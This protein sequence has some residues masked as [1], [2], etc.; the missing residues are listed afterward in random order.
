MVRTRFFILLGLPRQGYLR[1]L[2]WQ[3]SQWVLFEQMNGGSISVPTALVS[4]VTRLD[5][6]S[7]ENML[8]FACNKATEYKPVKLGT[9]RTVFLPSVSQ[10]PLVPTSIT[11][12]IIEFE[13]S[14]VVVL[15]W[16]SNPG[17]QNGRRSRIHG[18]MDE[19]KRK[20]GRDLPI[21]LKKVSVLWFYCIGP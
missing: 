17:P 16:D 4:S 7:Q 21:F 8:L 19:N 20:R 9:C 2:N 3:Y 14:G 12:S 1:Q 13:K 18:A 6:S 10:C 5:S 11:I 15:P